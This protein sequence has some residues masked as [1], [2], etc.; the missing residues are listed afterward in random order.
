[1]TSPPKAPPLHSP[2]STSSSLNSFSSSSDPHFPVTPPLADVSD[3]QAEEERLANERER[4][5]LAKKK[6]GRLISTSSSTLFSSFLSLPSPIKTLHTAPLAELEGLG[7]LESKGRRRRRRHKST[8]K[9]KK[10]AVK[11]SNDLDTLPSFQSSLLYYLS[12]HLLQRALSHFVFSIV[13]LLLTLVLA[14]LLILRIVY[15]GHDTVLEAL[16]VAIL[17]FFSVEI[18]LRLVA[19]GWTFF[20]HPLFLLSSTLT[21]LSFLFVLDAFGISILVNNTIA[22]ILQSVYSLLR[23]TAITCTL[24]SSARRMVSTNKTR[25]TAHGFD[26]DL[27]YITPRVI[28]MGLPSTSIEG[29]YRNPIDE[30]ARF[31]NTMHRGHYLLISLCSERR[32][33]TEPFEGRVLCFPFDD[34]NP[35]PLSTIVEFCT[36]VDR[37]LC[38]DELN[39]IAVHCRGGKGRT[40]TMIACWLLYASMT[41]EDGSDLSVGEGSLFAEEALKVFARARTEKGFGGKVQ[42]VSGPSQKR[43]VHYFEQ[44]RWRMA[45]RDEEREESTRREADDRA[46]K[47]KRNKSFEERKEQTDVPAT[48][49]TVSP[50]SSASSSFSYTI[51]TPMP[52]RSPA[53]PVEEKVSSDSSQRSSASS[54]SSPEPSEVSSPG[55]ARRK[56]SRPRRSEFLSYASSLLYHSPKCEVLSLVLNNAYVS[57]EKEALMY[58]DERSRDEWNDTWNHRDNWS[59]VITHYRPILPRSQEDEDGSDDLSDRALHGKA[60]REEEKREGEAEQSHP[61]TRFTPH[62]HLIDPPSSILRSSGSSSPQPR[63]SSPRPSSPP[64]TSSSSSP[65]ATSPR[66]RQLRRLKPLLRDLNSYNLH[67][68]EDV[69]EYYFK[70]RPKE[71]GD[72]DTSVTF[73]MSSFEENSRSLILSGD[74]KFQIYRGK[75]DVGEEDDADLTSTGG[76]SRGGE[77]GRPHDLAQEETPQRKISRAL[78]NPLAAAQTPRLFGWF[79]VNTAFLPQSAAGAGGPGPGSAVRPRASE[80][81]LRKNQ[82]DESFQASDI[83]SEFNVY[84][85]YFSPPLH[86]EAIAVEELHHGQMLKIRNMEEERRKKE[87]D[88]RRRKEGKKDAAAKDSAATK[89]GRSAELEL[90]EVK[91]AGGD[92]G[93]LAFGELKEEDGADDHDGAQHGKKL[94]IDSSE[95]SRTSESEHSSQID[96]ADDASVV[97]EEEE[98][99]EEEEAEVEAEAGQADFAA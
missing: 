50:I 35:P 68:Y 17:C 78:A 15:D 75:V 7:V 20:R 63:S 56:G 95:A 80:L 96:I 64:P 66:S 59:L 18:A 65:R 4:K 74:L 39:V 77:G 58:G 10:W 12:P 70:A 85:F 8:T 9:Q 29:L 46:G 44:L 23:L 22:L 51:A 88:E 54:P 26:L 30:V 57:K 21:L 47:R 91:T 13:V 3:A 61:P 36:T 53:S 62:S 94:S 99:V 5:K 60:E 89:K 31:F 69:H 41:T 71:A 49:A 27:T 52:I 6:K 11:E 84:L 1:M 32:Y 55:A 43:Y 82:L 16:A 67:R 86:K 24:T 14:V 97:D 45:R 25:Y 37:F 73:D 79:W 38:E 2:T 83:D 48:A 98:E 28:A 81:I 42:G 93:A 92:S 90:V 19:Y 72:D 40:G 33:D 87:R 34:H 76:R